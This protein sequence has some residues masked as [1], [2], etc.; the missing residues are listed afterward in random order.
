MSNTIVVQVRQEEQKV[1]TR[2]P[3]TAASST[4]ATAPV[5]S[6]AGISP[7]LLR[8]IEQKKFGE[9]RRKH[10]DKKEQDTKATWCVPGTYGSTGRMMKR[11]IWSNHGERYNKGPR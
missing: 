5:L 10:A 4:V 3:T 7:H 1:R 2:A 9:P 8:S 11:R 6:F